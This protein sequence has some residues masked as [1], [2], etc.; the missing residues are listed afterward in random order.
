MR[1]KRRI[2]LASAIGLLLWLTAMAGYLA[3][4]VTELAA[5]HD[6]FAILAFWPL[7]VVSLFSA[8]QLPWPTPWIISL[9]GW[10]SLAIFV[11]SVYH[12]LRSFTPAGAS[13]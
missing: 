7:A 10:V 13:S 12:F 5:L 3:S 9:A 1:I 6:P 2:L 11:A 8:A 4:L